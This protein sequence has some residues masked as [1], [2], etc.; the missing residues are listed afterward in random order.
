LTIELSSNSVRQTLETGKKIGASLKGGEIIGVYGELG[1]GK[2]HLI[3]GIAAGCGAETEQVTSPT[4]VLVNEY[5]G[6]VDVYHID[7]YRL[8]SVKEFEQ[9]GFD[10]L[11]YKRSVV[12]IE[13]ADRVEQALEGLDLIRIFIEHKS[14]E[15]RIIRL[16]NTPDYL[17]L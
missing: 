8:E 13:W 4:F 17:V 15:S 5:Y 16:E 10:E 11:C 3:K 12:L 9:L 7:A 1:A 14:S 2:T 6:R